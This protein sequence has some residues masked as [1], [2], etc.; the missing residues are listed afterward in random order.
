M[1]I[2]FD[3]ITP[4]KQENFKGGEK[5]ATLRAYTDGTNK[6]I[7]FTLIPGASIGFHTHEGTCETIYILE[8]SGQVLEN[9]LYTPITAGQCAYCP[10]GAG[11][12]LINNSD[13]NL[14]FFAMIAKQ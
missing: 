3:T 7:R 8:G 13:E 5:Y 1:I 11:H 10:D 2:D 9:G 12:S 14:E 4:E 6:M